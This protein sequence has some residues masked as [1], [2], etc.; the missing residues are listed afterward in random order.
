MERT[1]MFTAAANARGVVALPVDSTDTTL[2]R[3]FP[4]LSTSTSIPASPVIPLRDEFA[5]FAEEILEWAEL[6][7]AAGLECWPDDW[8]DQQA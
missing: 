7:H 8:S 4:W 6:S 2:T 3:T 1:G 5:V